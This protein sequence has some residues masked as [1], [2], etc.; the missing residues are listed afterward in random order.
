MKNEERMLNPIEQQ[1]E[2]EKA[3]SFSDKWE[4]ELRQK[5]IDEANNTVSEE[6][7][8]II[9]SQTNYHMPH[10][11]REWDVTIDEEIKYFDPE[12]SYEITGYRPITEEKGLD[13]DPEPFREM[14]KLY[15]LT[16]KYTEYPKDCKPYRDF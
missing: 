5:L 12:L 14:A 4:E 9:E 2:R 11:E 8:E 3:V 15:N 6:A 10:P 1:R 13:F 16:G 7:K